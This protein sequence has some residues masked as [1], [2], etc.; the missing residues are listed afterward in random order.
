VE[1]AM[2]VEQ[3]VAAV[4]AA[5]GHASATAQRRH[6]QI[7]LAIPPAPTESER[8]APSASQA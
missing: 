6:G 1:A 4:A 7:A 3:Q 5:V 2:Q 8:G